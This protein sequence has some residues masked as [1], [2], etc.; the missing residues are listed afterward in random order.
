MN[1]E[2]IGTVIAKLR[3]EKGTTQEELAKSVGVSAQAV[4]KWENGGVPDTELLPA[5]AD[6]FEVSTDT[7]FGRTI[8]DYSNVRNALINDII[9]TPQSEIFDKVFEYLWDIERSMMSVSIPNDGSIAE[10][11]ASMD[12][13]EQRY[14]SILSDNGITR[15]GI[16]NLL[17][18]FLL[19][20][21]IEDTE[22]ALFGGKDGLPAYDYPAFFADL[23]D[24]DFFDTLIMLHKR[25]G[26]KAFTPQLICKNLGFENDKAVQIMKKLENH[27]MVYKTEIEI[28]DGVLEV[29]NFAPSPS[30]IPL[31]IFAKEIMNPPSSFS[32]YSGGREKPYLK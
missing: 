4:S 20:P 11:S 5:I 15:M 31:L 14:S 1:T 7:L 23:G 8:E 12:E 21:E 22:A 26:C 2:K 3:K 10:Y 18:Y 19:I 32:W 30:L 27:G 16:G 6:Y 17:K 9:N 29:Y 13:K 28:D 24:R 25:E